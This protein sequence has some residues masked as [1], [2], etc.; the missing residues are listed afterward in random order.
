VP[1]LAVGLNWKGATKQGA[2]AS[3]TIGLLST[4]ILETLGYFKTFNLPS[5]VTVSGLS[6]VLSLLTFIGVS[7]VTK[8]VALDADVEMVME[9]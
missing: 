5:G 1:S 4:L 7:A 2:I 9:I 6:L 8:Q 3:I